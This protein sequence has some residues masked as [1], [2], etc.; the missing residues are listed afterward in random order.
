MTDGK[1]LEYPLHNLYAARDVLDKG[2]LSTNECYR[3][4]HCIASMQQEIFSIRRPL[5]TNGGAQENPLHSLHPGRDVLNKV[6]SHDRWRG[7]GLPN[8]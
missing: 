1:A 2:P 7:T 4:T 3:S 8:A 6:A 5:M